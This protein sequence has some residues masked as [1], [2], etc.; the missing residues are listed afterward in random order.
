MSS[1]PLRVL[2][3]LGY[4]PTILE[5]GDIEFR[6]SGMTLRFL[7]EPDDPTF[8]MVYLLGVWP[9]DDWDD[10][11]RDLAL[12]SVNRVNERIKV[13]RLL[14]GGSG[15]RTEAHAFY[16]SEEQLLRVLPDLIMALRVAGHS[17]TEDFGRALKWYQATL[18]EEEESEDS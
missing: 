2:Q 5:T 1:I 6:V 7:I 9:N 3:Q 4:R 17:F 14:V 10:A 8:A 11:I 18:D 13:S 16:Y 12:E 15:V